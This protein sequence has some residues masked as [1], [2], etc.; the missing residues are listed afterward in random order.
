MTQK[1]P[2]DQRQW[3]QPAWDSATAE[4]ESD[5]PPLDVQFAEPLPGT[6]VVPPAPAQPPSVMESSLTVIGGVIWPAAIAL[7]I[8]GVGSWMLNI[9]VALVFGSLAGAIASELK[10]RRKGR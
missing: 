7:A 9:A 4:A 10:K 5:P 1:P 8:F 2:D 3:Q 6:V